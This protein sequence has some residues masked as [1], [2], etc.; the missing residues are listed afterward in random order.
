[1]QEGTRITATSN[2]LSTTT[3]LAIWYTET[4]ELGCE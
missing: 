1:M 3:I 4:M 2:T